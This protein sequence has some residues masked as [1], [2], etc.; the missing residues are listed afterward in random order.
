MGTVIDLEVAEK[1]HF[2]GE[3]PVLFPTIFIFL[4]NDA[5]N[6]VLQLRFD[7][8]S[9]ERQGNYC[10]VKNNAVQRFQ[11][12]CYLKIYCSF[13]LFVIRRV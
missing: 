4:S 3:L 11:N 7:V 6:Q 2:N 1:C 9:H 10:F 13:H 8:K 5:S 12:C